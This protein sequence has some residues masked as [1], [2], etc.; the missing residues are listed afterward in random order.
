ML[1]GYIGGLMKQRVE[2]FITIALVLSA[3]VIAGVNV[4]RALARPKTTGLAAPAPTY[5]KEWKE[6][7]AAGI[8]IGDSTARIQMIEFADFECPFCRKFHDRYLSLKKIHGNSLSLV[9]IH[10]PLEGHRFARLAARVAEC[11]AAQNRFAEMHDVLLRKQDSMGIKPWSAYAAEAGIRDTASLNRCAADTV[12]IA[13]VETGLAL[14]KKLA[15]SGTPTTFINGWQ[16][17]GVPDSLANEVS[18]IA[19]GRA[20]SGIRTKADAGVVRAGSR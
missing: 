5:Y 12:T 4:Q 6:L 9:F 16:F 13:R 7:I 10:Y 8:R 14:A 3:V 18:L 2:A 20:P 15:L 11:A 17:F 19:A 1:H